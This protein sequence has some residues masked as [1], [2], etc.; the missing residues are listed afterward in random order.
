MI[1]LFSSGTAN[2]QIAQELTEFLKRSVPQISWMT[3]TMIQGV[4]AAHV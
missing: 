4:S 1:A 2:F 3:Q